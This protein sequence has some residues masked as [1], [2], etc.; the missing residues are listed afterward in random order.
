[1][2]KRPVILVDSSASNHV[3]NNANISMLIEDIAAIEFGLS[4]GHVFSA[5]R[6]GLLAIRI[7]E[8]TIALSNVHYIPGLH[9]NLLSCS[10]IDAK[11][12][13]TS[14]EIRHCKHIDRDDNYRC[15]ANVT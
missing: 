8:T 3:V 4:D 6:R 15:V 9:T 10:C 13:T 7:G 1:M 12:T 14:K 5:K 11:C 2:R